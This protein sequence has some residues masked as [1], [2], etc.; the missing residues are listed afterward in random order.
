M[1]CIAKKGTKYPKAVKCIDSEKGLVLISHVT[2][3]KDGATAV[4]MCY[5]L[6][7]DLERAELLEQA[8]RN[9][10]IRNMRGQLFR[11][12]SP[13]EIIALDGKLLKASTYR[14]TRE[15]GPRDPVKSAVNTLD[16]LTEDELTASL[17]QTY[18]MPQ[19]EAQ[20][21][22]KNLVAKRQ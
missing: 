15:K 2:T 6:E 19:K 17:E 16:K 14:P 12:L 9:W 7:L 3:A 1:A 13:Q 5:T 8:A 10:N 4:S 18:S 22:A 11:T 21:L 20:A